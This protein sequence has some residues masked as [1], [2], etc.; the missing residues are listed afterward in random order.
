LELAGGDDGRDNRTRLA[1]ER[2]RTLAGER[3][4]QWDVMGDDE[5]QAFVDD[6]IHEDRS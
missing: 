3:G 1:E 4:L 5:R 2:L 6:L